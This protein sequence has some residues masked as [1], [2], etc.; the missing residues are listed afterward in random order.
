[1]MK[2]DVF[3]LNARCVSEL[4]SMSSVKS[5]VVLGEI[6]LTGTSNPG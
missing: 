4:A 1:M 3:Y 6:G 5:K 2:S